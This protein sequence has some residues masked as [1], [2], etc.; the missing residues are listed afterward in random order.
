MKYL[1][2]EYPTCST[3]QKAKKWLETNQIEYTDRHIVEANPSEQELRRWISASGLPLKSF[4][5][6]SGLV[7]RALN[8]SEKLPSLSEDEQIKLL[9]S[10]GKLIKR[11]LLIGEKQILVG[12]KLDQW[13][14]FV[15]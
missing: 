1:F 12:F 14:Q 6:T 5:N 8:L 3:C 13:V 9:A 15:K 7:Y 10:D 2:I 11:P 4:F